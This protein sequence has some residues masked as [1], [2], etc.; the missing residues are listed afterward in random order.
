MRI[1]GRTFTTAGVLAGIVMI[2]IVAGQCAPSTPRG[3]RRMAA[4]EAGAA[5]QK[6]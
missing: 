6:T 5:A 3:Q 4:S 1:S 2:G